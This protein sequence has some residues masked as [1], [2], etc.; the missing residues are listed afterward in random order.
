MPSTSEAEGTAD[1]NPKKRKFGR[2]CR[3]L[4]V[5]RAWRAAKVAHWSP[6]TLRDK[7]I[8]IGTKVIPHGRYVGFQ[9]AAV[10]AFHYLFAHILGLNSDLQVPPAKPQCKK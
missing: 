1:E 7:R 9:M 5:V 3:K 10:A 6:I 4:R 8:K 2:E